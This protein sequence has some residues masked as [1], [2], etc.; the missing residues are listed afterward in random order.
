MVFYYNGGWKSV[1]IFVKERVLGWYDEIV[2]FGVMF[3]CLRVLGL[4]CGLGRLILLGFVYGI[5]FV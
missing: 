2:G 5:L 4:V 3:N 1:S